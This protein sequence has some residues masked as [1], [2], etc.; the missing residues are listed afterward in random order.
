[1]RDTP[2]KLHPPPQGRPLVFELDVLRMTRDQ[3]NQVVLHAASTGNGLPSTGKQ[4]RHLA[5]PWWPRSDPNQGLW[6]GR[7]WFP[8]RG[9][10]A[11]RLVFAVIPEGDV[12]R[13]RG[14]GTRP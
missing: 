10:E 1:R 9:K 8:R 3:I 4:E 12:A 13:E 11:S 2:C 14:G 7:L 6:G 5:R